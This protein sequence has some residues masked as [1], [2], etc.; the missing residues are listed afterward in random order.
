M[1]DNT[2]PIHYDIITL[3]GDVMIEKEGLKIHFGGA[4]TIEVE[5]L[6]EYLNATVK[7]LEIIAEETLS[8]EDHCKFIIENVQRGSFEL[9]ISIVKEVLEHFELVASVAGGIATAFVQI[10]Q[11]RKLLRGSKPIK[12]EHHEQGTT[13]TNI[14][15]DVQTINNTSYQIYV[16][17][18]DVEDAFARMSRV[19]VNDN[20]RTN[21]TVEE[22][23]EKGEVVNEVMYEEKDLKYTTEAVDISS[24]SDQIDTS[25]VTSCASIKRPCLKGDTQW[26]MI[27][28][29]IGRATLVNV[30]DKEF[31]RDVRNGKISFSAYTKIEGEFVIKTIT[32]P[33]GEVVGKPKISLVKVNQVIQEPVQLSFDDI[34]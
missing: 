17:N 8:K 7:C 16:N 27:L 25:T 1:I 19:L 9:I 10:L 6:A 34:D 21:L 15:G 26:E 24:L 28:S 23:D 29:A 22:R 13:I 33:R 5:T 20:A 30:N 31:L 32:N 11:C 12:V 4:D 18:P 3:R 14:N 2:D